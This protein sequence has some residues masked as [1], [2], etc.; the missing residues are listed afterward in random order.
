MLTELAPTHGG[1]QRT[2]GWEL[3]AN[4][5]LQKFLFTINYV[6]S[7][8]FNAPLTRFACFLLCFS[9][10]DITVLNNLLL[11]ADIAHSRVLKR[12]PGLGPI[13]STAIPPLSSCISCGKWVRIQ[14]VCL[15][16]QTPTD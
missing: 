3:L 1:D 4:I 16:P 2:S 6:F 7:L 11:A 9:K 12:V 15:S 8:H 14:N 10:N 13:P 5:S